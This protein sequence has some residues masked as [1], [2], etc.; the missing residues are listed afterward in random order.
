[1][2]FKVKSDQVISLKLEK[3]PKLTPKF[4]IDTA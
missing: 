4:V 1:M 3:N 2:V